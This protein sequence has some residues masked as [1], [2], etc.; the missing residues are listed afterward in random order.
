MNDKRKIK[1]KKVVTTFLCTLAILGFAESV[2]ATELQGNVAG[3]E[4][5]SQKTEAI[6]NLKI[7]PVEE[8]EDEIQF[9]FISEDGENEYEV[10]LS[11][12]NDYTTS[13]TAEGNTTYRL[14]YYYESYTTYEIEELKEEYVCENGTLWNLNYNVINRINPVES[15]L[16]PLWG[17]MSEE[18]AESL[19]KEEFESSVFPDMTQED[20]VEWYY[21]NVKDV[22]ESNAKENA[23]SAIT[24][25]IRNETSEAYFKSN[26]GTSE[27]WKALSDE[28]LI[29]FYYGC[30]LPS[31]VVE[32]NDFDFDEYIENIGILNKLCQNIGCEKLY[33]V[34]YT[35]WQ[36]IWEYQRSE[37]QMPNFPTLFITE[38]RAE[39]NALALNQSTEDGEVALHIE[40][41]EAE[42]VEG[43]NIV[44]QY[45]KEHW[46]SIVCLMIGGGVLIAFYY[47]EKKDKKG[48]VK[49]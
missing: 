9:L 6:F 49:R 42:S 31:I 3:T 43:T 45:L 21:E 17:D 15:T 25:G 44:F 16:V 8:F 13:F 46:F 41:N 20:V 40:S 38:Y 18:E 11:K 32:N 39:D 30:V 36:Y 27:E 35:L 7:T 5:T 12:S 24:K 10:T 33:D 26:S 28:K 14:M 22:I 19:Q 23:F 1:G 34:T 4:S 37:K 48:K 2:S 47:K 29:A